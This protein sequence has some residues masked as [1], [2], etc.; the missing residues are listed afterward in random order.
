MRTQTMTADQIF[1]CMIYRRIGLWRIV[2]SNT[3]VETLHYG[4]NYFV[5]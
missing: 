2:H 1:S 3:G 5:L 4:E